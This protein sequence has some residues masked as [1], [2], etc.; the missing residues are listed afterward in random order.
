MP[1]WHQVS[2]LPPEYVDQRLAEGDRRVGRML[3]RT[4]C[5]SCS[6][7]EPLR[8]LVDEFKPTKSQRRA[9]ARWEGLG[10]VEVGPPTVTDEKLA[11]YNRHKFGRNLA[12]DDA[13]PMDEAGYAGWLCVSCCETLEMRYYVGDR[14]VGV[15]IVDVG[16]TSMSSVYFYFDP[17]PEVAR[18]SPGVYST[19]QEI[20]LCRQTGRSYLYLGLYVADCVHLNY[21]AGFGPHERLVGGAWRREVARDATRGDP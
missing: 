15:G 3:Y 14:L 16:A 12:K 18:L 11:L 19:L 1:L 7:C 20:D 10:R 9:A 5:P 4:T 21:K 2:R 6:A 17:D 8:V 13:N